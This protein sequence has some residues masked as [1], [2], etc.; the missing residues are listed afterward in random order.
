MSFRSSTHD[1]VL[2]TDTFYRQKV[3]DAFSD[4]V[5]QIHVM[6]YDFRK[7]QDAI[8]ELGKTF[9][10]VEAMTGIDETTVARVL[11]TGRAAKSTALGLTKAFDIPMRDIQ[12]K[13]NDEAKDG[14]NLRRTRSKTLSQARMRKAG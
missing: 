7:I 9:K 10:E 12:V 14:K 4:H 2:A 1:R 6:R 5:I 8:N 13:R 11:R 3:L